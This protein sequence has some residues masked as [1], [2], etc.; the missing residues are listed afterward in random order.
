VL[1][2]KSYGSF[3]PQFLQKRASGGFEALQEEHVFNATLEDERAVVVDAVRENIAPAVLSSPQTGT[4]RMRNRTIFDSMRVVDLAVIM[5]TYAK[6]A[7]IPTRI[8][9]SAE[10]CG[11]AKPEST[12]AR[13]GIARKMTK[14]AN[15]RFVME[16]AEAKTAMRVPAR[17]PTK[18][19]SSRCWNPTVAILQLLP[20]PFCPGHRFFL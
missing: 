13:E 16:V 8:P 10:C 1:E 9:F 19:E 6:P 15:P 20:M 14:S 7:T 11:S 2:N 3:V 5:M 12:P 17:I 18:I 4:V